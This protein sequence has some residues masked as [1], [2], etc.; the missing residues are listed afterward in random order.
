LST[1][2]RIQLRTFTVKGSRHTRPTE[3]AFYYSEA[4]ERKYFRC[5]DLL[6]NS[7]EKADKFE[8]LIKIFHSTSPATGFFF[9]FRNRQANR[10]E[11]SLIFREELRVT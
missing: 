6:H 9:N 4:I 3:K 11:V 1:A 5:R 2:Q 10:I 8:L 7:I